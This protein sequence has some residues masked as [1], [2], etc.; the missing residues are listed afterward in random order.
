MRI[1]PHIAKSIESGL[2]KVALNDTD[3]YVLL[4]HCTPEF[5]KFGLTELL[6]EYDIGIKVRFAPLH[7]LITRLHQ[8]ICNVL[9]A[10][11]VTSK[12]KTKSEALRSNPH[13][14]LNHLVKKN[15]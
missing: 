6:L 9:T 8:N 5:I 13:V 3:I 2:K 4:L 1:I 14:Y 15:Y 7:F 12:I 10:C 11:D